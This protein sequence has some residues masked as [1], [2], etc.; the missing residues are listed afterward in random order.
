V[1]VGG[2]GTLS[3]APPHDL[4]GGQRGGGMARRPGKRPQHPP[5]PVSFP[6]ATTRILPMHL[7]VGDRFSDETGEWELIAV[8]IARREDRPC[9]SSASRSARHGSGS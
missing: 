8:Y 2:V 5:F 1:R 3:K 4:G 9:A 7:R 6:P